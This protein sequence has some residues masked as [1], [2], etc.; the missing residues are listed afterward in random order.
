[1]QLLHWGS[2]EGLA[3]FLSLLTWIQKQAEKYLAMSKDLTKEAQWILPRLS[4]TRI[5]N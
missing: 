2:N 1:M 4:G 3:N 5:I